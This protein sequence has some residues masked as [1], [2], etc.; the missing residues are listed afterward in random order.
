M[1]VEENSRS[2]S[3]LATE[4]EDAARGWRE[5]GHAAPDAA[6]ITGSGLGL[7]VGERLAGPW[8]FAELLPFDVEAIEGH[9]V[10]AELVS[11]GSDLRLL[12]CRGRLHAYQGYTP[13][14]VVFLVRL[15]ALLGAGCLIVTNAAGSLNEE[16]PVGSVAAISDH[17]N[18]TGLNPLRGRL[19]A[20]WGPQFPDL[21]DAYDPALR[22]RLAELAAQAGMTM[23]E[24]VYLG[25][26]GPS[27][28]TP[29]E[30]RAFRGMGADLVG[31]STVLEVIAARHMG[32]R[33]LGLSLVTNMGVGL[34][35]DPID[36]QDVLQIGREASPG[37]ARLIADLL[38]DDV[39][40]VAD[41]PNPGA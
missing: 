36:H 12:H 2:D 38:A 15:A 37:V 41:G 11:T 18:L 10:S 40:R 20:D 3:S 23:G 26:L 17:V 5:A 16:L 1:N 8:P 7:E 29:A 13:G 33:V 35:D 28:E 34:A 25:V 39:V 9:A 31:M 14:Q 19:P 21:A 24:G 32:M 4:L 27:F 22:H 6:L 30:I